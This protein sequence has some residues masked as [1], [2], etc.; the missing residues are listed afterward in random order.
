MVGLSKIFSVEDDPNAERK[1]QTHVLSLLS[2]LVC[3]LSSPRVC[4][5]SLS[6]WTALLKCKKN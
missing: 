5:R 2:M 6:I 3:F 1:H 4:W